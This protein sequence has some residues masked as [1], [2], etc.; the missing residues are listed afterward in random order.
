MAGRPQL[1]VRRGPTYAL[2]EFMD[3]NWDK[4]VGRTN[5][6]VAGEL[7]YRSPNMISMWRTGKT[8]VPLERIPDIAR[9][10]KVDV[11]ALLNLWFEQSWGERSDAKQL[12]KLFGSRLLHDN[13][14]PLMEAVRSVNKKGFA[15]TPDKLAAIKAVVA[16]ENLAH[17]VAQKASAPAAA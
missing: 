3:A 11:A 13:E 10:M 17:E 14:L 16:D 2:S 12:M 9:L 6:D 8:R 1:S 15:M 7:G 4:L 5:E